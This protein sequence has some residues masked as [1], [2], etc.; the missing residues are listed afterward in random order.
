MFAGVA[1]LTRMNCREPMGAF[2]ERFWTAD[3]A[4]GKTRRLSKWEDRVQGSSPV[5]AERKIER[6]TKDGSAVVVVGTV[7]SGEEMPVDAQKIGTQRA[8]AK[9]SSY[10]Q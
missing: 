10:S 7:Y 8:V 5:T 3:V 2:I 1:I 4:T 6:W 9:D